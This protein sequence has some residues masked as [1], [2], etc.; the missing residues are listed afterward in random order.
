MLCACV[1]SLPAL[2]FASWPGR[3]ALPLPLTG[4]APYD[5]HHDER[6]ARRVLPLPPPP[7][8]AKDDPYIPVAHP[9]GI[10]YCA[11]CG[12]GNYWGMFV[13]ALTDNS[14][15]FVSPYPNDRSS[16]FH[17][18]TAGSG[19]SGVRNPC[20][21]NDGRS[22][23]V[24]RPHVIIN[25]LRQRDMPTRRDSSHWSKRGFDVSTFSLLISSQCISDTTT[26]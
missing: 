9:V 23:H 17:D 4:F 6:V 26:C 1:G 2:L 7:L 8:G 21:S 14:A 19:R 24:H 10:L 12:V 13:T 25:V 11:L 22:G 20:R 18:V 5:L 16:C 3:D 15:C